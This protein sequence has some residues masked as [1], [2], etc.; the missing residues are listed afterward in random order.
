MR[1]SAALLL[2]LSCSPAAARAEDV[3]TVPTRGLSL[4][5]MQGCTACH[6]LDG[7]VSAGPTFYRRFGEATQVVVDGR[8]TTVVFN[9]AYIR[10]SLE[11]PSG[12]LAPGYAPGVMPRFALT[13]EQLEAIT[14]AIA[15]V[16]KEP[17]PPRPA[18][19]RALLAGALLAW[20]ALLHILIWK[21]RARSWA[22][23]RFGA[24]GHGALYGMLLLASTWAASWLWL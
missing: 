10:A 1:V 24:A 16:G 20:A 2:L 12:M 11:D 5:R 23:S 22:R 6:S 21:T 18:W 14:E 9:E 15:Y 19:G 3:T 17:A 4:L 13:E 8:T 7:S